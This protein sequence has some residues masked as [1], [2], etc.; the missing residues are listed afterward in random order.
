MKKT[1]DLAKKSGL[2]NTALSKARAAKNDEFYTR[3]ESIEAELKHY[4]RHFVGKVVYCN[5]DDPTISEFYLFFKR[6]FGELGLKKLLT[7]C[8]KNNEADLW[9]QHKD[10]NGVQVIYDGKRK[11]TKC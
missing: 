4:R 10:A 8:Y 7:T 5:C 2:T 9:S 3:R 1:D 11:I 6:N